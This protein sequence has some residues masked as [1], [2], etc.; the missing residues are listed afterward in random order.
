MKLGNSV[1]HDR[2]RSTKLVILPC[3]GNRVLDSSWKRSDTDFD[4]AELAYICPSL[5]CMPVCTVQGQVEGFC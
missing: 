2:H 3:Q 1:R 4:E 5:E